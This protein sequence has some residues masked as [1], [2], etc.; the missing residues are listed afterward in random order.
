MMSAWNLTGSLNST[1]NREGE[2]LNNYFGLVVSNKRVFLT[3]R[4]L[5]IFHEAE[6]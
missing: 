5:V 1:Q 2:L 3:D 6:S 4:L